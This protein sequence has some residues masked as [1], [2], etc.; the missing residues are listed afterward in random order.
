MGGRGGVETQG[1]WLV[2]AAGPCPFPSRWCL[3]SSTAY[4]LPPLVS[5]QPFFA[6]PSQQLIYNVTPAC[7]PHP[8]P[9][10]LACSPDLHR[11]GAPFGGPG[12]AAVRAGGPSPLVCKCLCMGGAVYYSSWCSSR[13]ALQLAEVNGLCN[14][15]ATVMWAPQGRRSTHTGP[16][17]A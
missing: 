6:P 15:S 2:G 10:Y 7:C 14:I 17:Q 3:R 1:V 9:H 16:G 4:R 11:G 12:H 8:P 5:A 13:T